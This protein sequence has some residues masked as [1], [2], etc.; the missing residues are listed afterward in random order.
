MARPA[1]PARAEAYPTG[2]PGTQEWDDEGWD[3]ETW[4]EEV[5]APAGDGRGASRSGVRPRVWL[6]ITAAILVAAFGGTALLLA[7]QEPGE[8]TTNVVGAEA[9]AV[10]PLEPPTIPP[11]PGRVTVGLATT[12]DAQVRVTVDGVVEFDGTLRRGQRQEWEGAERIQVWTDS[13]KSVQLAVNG[14][15]LGAYSPAMG[16]PD[17]NRIDYG[18]WPGWAQ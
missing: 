3:D 12:Q 17:W 16:H 14:E 4:D 18:F 1:L 9:T 5:L 11:D 2:A 13:G 15:D 6:P 10:D 7:E 8:P